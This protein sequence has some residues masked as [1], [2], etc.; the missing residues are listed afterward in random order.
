M[1]NALHT[2]GFLAG[3]VLVAV[4]L[5]PA[6][7]ARSQGVAGAAATRHMPASVG[8]YVLTKSVNRTSGLS[9][10]SPLE[11]SEFRSGNPPE[12]AAP[13]ERIFKAAPV[14]FEGVEWPVIVASTKD[15]IYKIALEHPA[16]NSA[17][18]RIFQHMEQY[19]TQSIGKPSEYA[20]PPS[21]SGKFTVIIWDAEEGNLV[22]EKGDLNNGES[23]VNWYLTSNII[24]KAERAG[25]G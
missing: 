8:P 19:F 18:N 7:N 22:L 10:F 3:V 11:Y 21:T 9:E 6:S 20:N 13:A 5:I 17:V 2:V 23:I 1:M 24:A 15:R 25:G 4:M 16:D 14:R 12:A